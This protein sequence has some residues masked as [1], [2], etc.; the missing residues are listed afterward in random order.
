MWLPNGNIVAVKCLAAVL[1]LCLTLCWRAQVAINH[2]QFDHHAIVEHELLKAGPDGAIRF[3]PANSSFDDVAP[4]I[5]IGIVCR[6][7]SRLWPAMRVF[8][9][10]GRTDTML[11]LPGE[12]L[13]ELGRFMHLSWQDEDG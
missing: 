2:R 1:V 7:S 6:W 8:R 4:A 3:E 9:R 5:V 12:H 11:A 10:D 13:L